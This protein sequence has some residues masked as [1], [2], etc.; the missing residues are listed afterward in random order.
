MCGS[1]AS[2]SRASAR[3]PPRASSSCCSRTRRERSTSSS[4]RRST[5]ATASPSAPSRS[6]WSRACS[7]ASRRPGAP[8]TSWSAASRRSTRPTCSHA[9]PTP[10]VKDFSMLDARELAR[11]ALEQPRVAVAAAGGATAAHVRPA[12]PGIAAAPG[13]AGGECR[14]GRR[15]RDHARHDRRGPQLRRSGRRQP[16]RRQPVRTGADRLRSARARR[17]RAG[18]AA[19]RGRHRRRGLPGRGTADHE[20]R[21]GSAAMMGGR[22]CMFPPD[23]RRGDLR[24]RVPGPRAGRDRL[25]LQ[26]QGGAPATGVGRP[27]VPAAASWRSWSRS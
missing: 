18:R 15:A 19:S 8:S 12:A 22:T 9:V 14:T 6:W 26:R 1:A 13:V 27:R 25:R 16:G 21:P 5:R 4:R 17:R 3:G 24:P 11:I 2:S 10:E 7:S 20:L 23:D